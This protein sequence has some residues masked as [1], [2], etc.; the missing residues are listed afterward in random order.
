VHV[1]V[2]R[3]R[4]ADDRL[5]QLPC[6]TSDAPGGRSAGGWYQGHDNRAV[7]ACRSGVNV[8][9]YGWATEAVRGQLEANGPLARIQPELRRSGCRGLGWGNLIRAQERSAEGSSASDRA[10]THCNRQDDSREPGEDP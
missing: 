2:V 6:H 5:D 1:D 4:V 10:T 3:G 8:G 9:C 7:R